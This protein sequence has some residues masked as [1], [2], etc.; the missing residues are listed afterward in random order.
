MSSFKAMLDTNIVSAIGRSP[1]L[2]SIN[3][4]LAEI[5]PDTV[6][7]SIVTAAE[8]RFGLSKSPSSK[9]R[10]N[11][12]TLLGSIPILPF[13]VPADHHYAEIRAVLVRAGTPIGSNDLLIAAH[14]LA[15]D[16]T[17]ITDNVREFARVPGL[18]V[19]NWLD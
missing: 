3:R 11:M 5:G 1:N 8:I 4:H 9:A 18:R 15:L 12:E 2:P 19:E 16:L 14:A 13:D 17:L 6:C 10:A 7:M